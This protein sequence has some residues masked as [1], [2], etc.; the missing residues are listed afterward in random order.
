MELMETKVCRV[1]KIEKELHEYYAQPVIRKNKSGEKVKKIYHQ[2][3]CKECAKK[4]NKDNYTPKKTD[5]VVNKIGK[6]CVCCK[7]FKEYIYF[8]RIFHKKNNRTYYQSYCKGCKKNY[9]KRGIN[10]DVQKISLYEQDLILMDTMIKIYQERRLKHITEAF[11][12]IGKA[13]LKRLAN[14]R[15]NK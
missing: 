10:A 6:D 8:S 9:D 4:Y 14:E 12:V 7:Q 5:E 15:L 13:E 3:N 11:E 1:C 2:S